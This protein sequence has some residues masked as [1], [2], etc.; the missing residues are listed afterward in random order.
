[1]IIDELKFE[2]LK[3][4]VM[5]ATLNSLVGESSA[6]VLMPTKDASYDNV[7]RAGNNIPDAKILLASYVN[8]RDLL[9]YQK[10]VMPL[11]TLDIL[12]A[13]LGKE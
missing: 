9:G 11:Q 13:Q 7:T 1:M 8:I 3:T 6:L 4:K 10:V 12:S 2:E 5:A